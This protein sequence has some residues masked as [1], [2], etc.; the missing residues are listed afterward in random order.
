MI[1]EPPP[2]VF[3]ECA[4]LDITE[5]EIRNINDSTIQR[6]L[7]TNSIKDRE[8]AYAFFKILEKSEE[9][10]SDLGFY[11]YLVGT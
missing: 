8:T 10:S 3:I 11:H 4:D 9:N 6:Y 1:T 7:E 2:L 5:G